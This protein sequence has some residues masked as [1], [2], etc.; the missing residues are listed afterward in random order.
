M[1]PTELQVREAARVLADAEALVI[2][3]GAGMG[4][5][6]GLPDFRGGGG[7]WTTVQPGFD[8]MSMAEADLFRGDPTLAWGF[9]GN[10]L[11]RYREVTPHRGFEV[12]LRLVKQMPLGAFVVTSNV[13][14]QFQRAGF[15]PDLVS[16]VH[17]SIHWNQC[18]RICQGPLFESPAEIVIDEES[19]RMVS[20]VPRCPRCGAVA[21]PNILMFGDCWWDSSRSSEQGDRFSRWL[22]KL[23]GARIAIVEC[24]AGTRISTIRSLSERLVVSLGG[25]LI[26]INPHEFGVPSG[27][28]EL[29]LGARE[30]LEWIGSVMEG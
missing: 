8:P 17:G 22:G 26:R 12:L 16:E 6:S 15:D 2:T 28:I 27:Q 3:A 30:A 5:D 18:T 21:R 10:R 13:D 25:R 19:V 9:Y 7:L 1:N 4:V 29:G 23:A 11:R 14:G 24:G 20:P